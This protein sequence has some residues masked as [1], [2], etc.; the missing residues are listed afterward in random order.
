MNARFI[1]ISFRV[2]IVIIAVAVIFIIYLFNKPHRNVQKSDAYEELTVKNLI[3]EFKTDEAKANAKYL[4]QD[5][6]SKI[7]IVSGVV[8]S[9]TTNQKNEKVVLLKEQGEKMGVSCVFTVSSSNEI[10]EL[11]IGQTVKIKGAIT[12]G[13]SYDSNLDLYNDA[14]LIQCALAK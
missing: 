1:K 3:N 11:K 5:G 8:F 12:A 7:L 6:N 14:I 9:I 2:A 13:N 10:T 4:S